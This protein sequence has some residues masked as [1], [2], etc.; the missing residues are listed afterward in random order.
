MLCFCQCRSIARLSRAQIHL[1]VILSPHHV[2]WKDATFILHSAISETFQ[3]RMVAPFVCKHT[4]T[5]THTHPLTTQSPCWLVQAYQDHEG[6]L[7][8]AGCTVALK[9]AFPGP[10]L[11]IPCPIYASLCPNSPCSTTPN[12]LSCFTT[13]CARLTA[14]C[15]PLSIY[16][17]IQ[18][19]S[20]IPAVYWLL[21]SSLC[22]WNTYIVINSLAL[23]CASSELKQIRDSNW[24]NSEWNI[25][26]V[27]HSLP[28]SPFRFYRYK[29]IWHLHL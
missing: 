10:S 6:G 16:W 28:F 4:H 14:S 8:L 12:P 11:T 17:H 29:K 5:H 20:G 23:A 25:I 21:C 26:L 22:L 9:P 27:Y 13:T 2:S 24:E 15:G 19:S 18:K 3:G 7:D 1:T